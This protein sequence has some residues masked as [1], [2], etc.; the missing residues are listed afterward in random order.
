[1]GQRE[2]RV[3]HHRGYICNRGWFITAGAAF[4]GAGIIVT[5]MHFGGHWA[6]FILAAV[7][8]VL[9][10]RSNRRF[11]SSQEQED[12]DVLFQTIISTQNKGETWRMLML[13]ISE[14]RHK[15][16]TFAARNYRDMTSAFISEKAGVL[17][18]AEN[19]LSREKNVLKSVRR[20]ET[21]CLRCLPR[22]TAIEKSTWFYLS[23]NLCMSILYNLRR[24]NEVCKEHVENNFLPLPARYTSE[25]EMLQSRIEILFND[26][27][28][29]IDNGDVQTIPM[30]RRHCDDIKDEI[31]VSYH[32]VQD[33][34]SDGDSASMT[35]LF[36][37]VNILQ[38][39]QEMVSSIR[40]YLR[41]YA[42]L[43]DS[44][45]RTRP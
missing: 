30:L 34:L 5:V 15:F 17:N 1:M 9:I 16:F 14:Q 18:K 6:M 4:I 39:T 11:K 28:E 13:Y 38:E 42:K 3:P 21:L 44:E 41:A 23:N 8:V 31:S 35:V 25:Y 45:F 27:L 43:C 22:E 33:H 12:G 32:R 40:K 29:V 37:Y 19:I 36:V 20:K 2:C 26:T 7:T 10:I 24:I